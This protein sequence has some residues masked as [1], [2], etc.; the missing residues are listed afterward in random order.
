MYLTINSDYYIVLGFTI[1]S[2][3]LAYFYLK[4][5]KQKLTVDSLFSADPKQQKYKIH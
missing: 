4:S 2:C 5:L 1:D 3:C